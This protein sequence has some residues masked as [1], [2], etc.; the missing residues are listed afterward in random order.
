MLLIR[1]QYLLSCGRQQRRRDP[2]GWRSVCCNLLDALQR[3]M[4]Q[5]LAPAHG[6]VEVLHAEALTT[7]VVNRSRL[8]GWGTWFLGRPKRTQEFFRY[9]WEGM[10]ECSHTSIE[11][12]DQAILTIM[13]FALG[14]QR[15]RREH[16][17]KVS[18]KSWAVVLALQRGLLVYLAAGLD[19]YLLQVY[20]PVRPTP[21]PAPSYRSPKKRAVVENPLL[22]R[23]DDEQPPRQYVRVDA[24]TA[25]SLM[26]DASRSGAH[27]TQVA[28]V[29]R[30]DCQA[31]CGGGT[32][33]AWLVRMNAMYRER[34]RLG[35]LGSDHLNIVADPATHSKRDTMASIIWSWQAG[36]AAHGDLQY[37]PH[38]GMLPTE[39]EMPE[40]I[41]QLYCERRLERMSAFRQVQALSN[42]IKQLGM[43]SGIDDF[44]LPVDYHVDPVEAGEVRVLAPAQDHGPD[45]HNYAVRVRIA[46]GTAL[47][48]LPDSAFVPSQS[49]KLL[50]LNLD[51]GGVGAAGVAFAQESM[52]IMLYAHWD[53]FHRVIRDINLALGRSASGLFLKTRIYSAHLWSIN[54]KP[55]GTGLF[56]TQKLQLLNAF[57]GTQSPES[58]IFRRYAPIDRD[59]LGQ[60]AG[61]AG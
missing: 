26:E 27:V 51:Q 11:H 8:S 44:Q 12:D 59:G 60:T 3:R 14:F 4:E 46:E 57:M 18:P 56:G 25:W 61:H 31:G 19:A 50:V 28:A 6:N 34:R 49:Y 53:K 15:Q 47:R 35:L 54:F 10:P 20:L 33:M 9:L 1:M 58:P 13:H 29:R 16:N 24:E 41:A 7:L 43:W 40:H 55:W 37:I 45:T 30:D 5:P 52:K 32:A 2:M 22:Q 42:T 39:Q 48:V 36:I 23:R 38:G 17:R 21:K